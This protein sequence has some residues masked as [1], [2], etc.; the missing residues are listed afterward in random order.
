[1]SLSY[2]ELSAQ[3]SAL[4]AQ[5][6][7]AQKSEKQGAIQ[8]AMALIADYDISEYQ[9]FSRSISRVPLSTK[10]PVLAKYKIEPLVEPLNDYIKVHALCRH[11]I[12][13][14]FTPCAP[15]IK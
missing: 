10:A 6:A 7:A 9:L 2:K 8:E 3:K 11:L 5:I 14:Y 15:R 13:I 12:D 1:M 4:D